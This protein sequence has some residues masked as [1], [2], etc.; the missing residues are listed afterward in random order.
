[1]EN[2]LFLQSEVA[3]PYAIYER[4]RAHHPVYRDV[5]NGIWAVYSHAHCKRVLQAGP[6]HIPGQNPVNAHLLN[7]A[8]ASLA[9][10]LARLANPPAHPAF[11]Q[12][13]LR[14]FERMQAANTAALL[15]RL[16]DAKTREVDWVD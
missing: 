9:S 14:L 1:M 8:A 12:A 5:R 4:M 13:V 16:L 15:A 3:D 11:R 7:D 2:T 6:A 10:K